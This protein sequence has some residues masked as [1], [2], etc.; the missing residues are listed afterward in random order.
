[1]ILR[2]SSRIPG[3]S[4]DKAKGDRLL[5]RGGGVL[6]GIGA[7]LAAEAEIEFAGG[8]ATRFSGIGASIE[9][10]ECGNRSPRRRH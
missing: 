7:E 3:G 6:E 4:H 10:V 1:M 2:A 8:G 9:E 5:A